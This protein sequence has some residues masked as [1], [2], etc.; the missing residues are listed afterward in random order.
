MGDYN[1]NLIKSCVGCCCVLRIRSLF[2][3]CCFGLS[4]WCGDYWRGPP[5]ASIHLIGFF[6]S[7]WFIGGDGEVM[8]DGA[9]CSSFGSDPGIP[10]RLITFVDNP[11]LLFFCFFFSFS[12]YF[13][14]GIFVI[15]NCQRASDEW[16]TFRSIA[17][18]V[19]VVVSSLFDLRNELQ[20]YPV[21]HEKKEKDG[22]F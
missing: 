3:I 17:V 4:V 21:T 15:V 1:W 13:I 6:L 11:H 7:C 2:L 18:V 19:V 8:G 5:L 14:F 20:S 12:L 22:Y 9:L 10:N 16:D